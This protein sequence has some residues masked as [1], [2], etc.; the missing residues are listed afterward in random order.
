[1]FQR[2]TLLTNRI[3]SIN[4]SAITIGKLNR[5]GDIKSRSIAR[6]LIGNGSQKC[7]C[8]ERRNEIA[9]NAIPEMIRLVFEPTN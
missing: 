7:E 3:T 4:A 6:I 1:M 5:T 9:K 2:D 8:A